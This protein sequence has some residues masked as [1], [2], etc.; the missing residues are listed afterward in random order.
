LLAPDGTKHKIEVLADGQQVV[1][2]GAH[3]DTQAPYAWRW[4][5]SPVTIAHNKLPLIDSDEAHSIIDECVGELEKRLGWK[6]AGGASA[7]AI[8]NIVLFAPISERIEGMQYGGEFPINDTLL[9]YTG[10]QLRNCVPCEEVQ[11]LHGAGEEGLRR[12]PRRPA[13]APDLELEQDGPPDPRDGLR[14]YL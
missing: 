11:R 3:P 4:G 8:N 5:H 13:S 14:L 1:V 7:A 12:N 2:A 9:A 6:L 10:D